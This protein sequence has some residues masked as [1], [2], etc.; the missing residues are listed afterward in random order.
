VVWQSVKVIDKDHPRFNE[1]GTVQENV[2]TEAKK[3]L[4]KFDKDGATEPVS[5]DSLEVLR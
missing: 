4:V 3:A 1:A 2:S 5:V